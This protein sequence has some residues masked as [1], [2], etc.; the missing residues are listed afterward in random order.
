MTRTRDVTAPPR[1]DGQTT[2]TG[3]KILRSDGVTA[4]FRSKPEKHRR[5]VLEP[6]LF[7][8]TTDTEWELYLC[9]YR[10]GE[11]RR[12]AM[13]LEKAKEFLTTELRQVT[14]AID[15]SKDRHTAKE[16]NP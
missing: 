2:S 15:A 12:V 11:F 6:K 14:D 3:A 13:P 1:P 8:R 5:R 16:E 7:A 4:I 9:I 10:D